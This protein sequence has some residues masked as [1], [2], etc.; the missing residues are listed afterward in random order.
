MH[1]TVATSS[2]LDY[3]GYE[4]NEFIPTKLLLA[5]EALTSPRPE[6]PF[7]AGLHEDSAETSNTRSEEEKTQRE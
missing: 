2:L 7:H 4:R 3:A 1:T 6:R 5:G